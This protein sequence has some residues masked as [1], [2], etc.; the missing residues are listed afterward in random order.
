MISQIWEATTAKRM[1]M[2]VYRQ[3]QNSSPLNVL[4][5]DAYITLILLV[6]PPLGVDNQNTVGEN[7]DF[8][9][10]HTK[11]SLVKGSGKVRGARREAR[12][13]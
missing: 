12:G 8:Q 5:S 3:R 9:P 10:L 6:V 1:K 4:F 2:D 11:I 7:G 13:G